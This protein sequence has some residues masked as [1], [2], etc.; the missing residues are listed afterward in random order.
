MRSLASDRETILPRELGRGVPKTDETP[1]YQ[2]PQFCEATTAA[3]EK[4]LA[5]ALELFGLF[6]RVG[7]QPG[8]F[9]G[10]I[11]RRRSRPARSGPACLAKAGRQPEGSRVKPRGSGGLVDPTARVECF[12]VDSDVTGR[13]KRKSGPPKAICRRVVGGLGEPEREGV[14]ICGAIRTAGAPLIDLGHGCKE[15]GNG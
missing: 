13:R 9:H 2:G 5:R 7:T 14:E 12:L 1:R 6:V 15:R 10:T 4:A 3:L 11:H 8:F